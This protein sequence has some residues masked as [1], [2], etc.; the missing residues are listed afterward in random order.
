M[1]YSEAT[2]F[3]DWII[4]EY[5]DPR[6]GEKA[7]AAL[8]TMSDHFREMVQKSYEAGV[9]DGRAMAK[10]EQEKNR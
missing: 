2:I 5:L 1:T 7:Q 3:L 6:D 9:K 4:A 8:N 10:A